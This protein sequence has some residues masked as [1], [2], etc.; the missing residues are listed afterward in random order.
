M[1]PYLFFEDMN[2]KL[3]LGDVSGLVGGPKSQIKLLVVGFEIESPVQKN[4]ARSSFET[5][6]TTSFAQ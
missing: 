5:K 1:V 6:Q 2:D 3:W 4:P